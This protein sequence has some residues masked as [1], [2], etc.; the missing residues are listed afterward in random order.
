M[1]YKIYVIKEVNSDEIRYI[2]LTKN[3]I[4]RRL[5]DHIRDKKNKHK[6]NWIK[7][8]GK[9]N[10]EIVIIEENI[11]S[12]EEVCVKEVKYISEYRKNGHRLVN[13]SNGGDGNFNFKFSD[14]HKLNISKN[15]ADVS[16][17]KNPMYG[18]SHKESSVSKIKDRIAKWLDN[19]GLTDD[20]INNIIKSKIGSKNPKAI[21]NESQVI[22]IREMY[23]NGI[24]QKEIS[25]IYNIN[26]PMVYK[27]VHRINW[28][29]I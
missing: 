11:S 4:N 13:I 1:N 8:V 24:T 19:G 5:N 29:H 27:I 15:H 14:E 18:R 16:G 9:E 21:I 12:I 25:V 28:K 7:K 2:G 23:K 3:S 17:N 6:Y 26:P 10:I 22:E 20:Q